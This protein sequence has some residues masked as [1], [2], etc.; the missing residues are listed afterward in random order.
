MLVYQRCI[1]FVGVGVLFVV[2]VRGYHTQ[3]KPTQQGADVHTIP[4]TR[5]P[6]YT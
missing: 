4:T 1:C 6:T 2:V 5:A 3:N